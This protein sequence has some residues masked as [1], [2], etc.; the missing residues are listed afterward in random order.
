MITL[1]TTMTKN[2]TLSFSVDERSQFFA[3]MEGILERVE[4]TILEESGSPTAYIKNEDESR[5]SRHR[6]TASLLST[7]SGDD[8][9]EQRS[10][11]SSMDLSRDSTNVVA[12]QVAGR[13]TLNDE[14]KPFV[15]TE[16][17]VGNQ[18]SRSNFQQRPSH[19]L[20]HTGIASPAHTN[21]T[22]DATF[23]NE[24]NE[25]SFVRGEDNYKVNAK[26]LVRGIDNRAME[27]DDDNLSTVTPILD[28]Y[29]LDPSDDNSIGVKV[30]P[31]KRSARR[32]NQRQTTTPRQNSLPTIAQLSPSLDY[33]LQTRTPKGERKSNEADFTT[34]PMMTSER[35]MRSMAT[36]SS[37]NRN[38]KVYR[39]TPFP[40]R[41]QVDMEEDDTNY[42]AADEN[43]DPNVS[44][45]SSIP[46]SPEPFS[47]SVPPL[48]PSSFEPKRANETMFQSGTKR[49]L[50]FPEK[51]NPSLGSEFPAVS[52]TNEESN[53]IRRREEASTI[54]KI[55]ETIER[56]DKEL[57]SPTRSGKRGPVAK[58]TV[59]GSS[60]FLIN[61]I[62]ETE[63]ESAPRIV[64]TNVSRDRANKA[65]LS[66]HRYCSNSTASFNRLE[67]TEREGSDI[68]G[69]SDQESKSVLIS[70]CHWRR[71]MMKKDA[72]QGL[73]FVIN[74]RENDPQR[75][76]S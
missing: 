11:A 75:I 28:R 44:T 48:R 17:S 23:T 36:S 51:N 32:S 63:F 62:T 49:S 34:P 4:E 60:E 2:N 59:Q 56:I 76:F 37:Q 5:Y 22:M 68:L 18:I 14:S 7:Q 20:I 55:D 1:D 66:I 15:S 70:L 52:F 73:T 64:R 50:S 40:N 47:I 35:H 42:I 12:T 8:E 58:A 3:R 54:Q 46:D 19:I 53:Q 72:T 26:P 24:A 13:V 38:R 41:K 31:N 71:I 39:K 45:G 6:Q 27:E 25:A 74:N 30:V 21:I 57:A 10:M 33:I 61:E 69:F 9:D 43:H 67:F 16:N 65:L 29:R